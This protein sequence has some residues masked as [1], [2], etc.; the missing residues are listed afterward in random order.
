MG[1]AES[2]NSTF[3]DVFRG[4]RSLIV[5]KMKFGSAREEEGRPEMTV[6]AAYQQKATN[7]DLD[8]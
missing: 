1:N 5:R 4:T 2:A 8:P 3:G 7:R 6:C